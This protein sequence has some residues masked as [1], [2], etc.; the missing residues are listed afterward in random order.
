MF[1]NVIHY[2]IIDLVSLN[3]SFSRNVIKKG[4]NRFLFSLVRIVII[5]L[6]INNLLAKSLIALIVL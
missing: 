2:S 6:F 3:S 1:L 4:L 5:L